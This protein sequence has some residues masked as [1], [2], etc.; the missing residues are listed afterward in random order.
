MLHDT[1][2]AGIGSPHGADR[3][4]WAVIDAL[5]AQALPPSVKL[6]A[7]S[8]PTEL[9]PL[10][11]SSARVIVVDA[12]LGAGPAGA[13]HRLRAAELPGTALRLSS[14]GVGL[15]DA[16]LLASALGMPEDRLWVL[17]LDVLD[18]EAEIEA[19]WIR[20]LVAQVT[21]LLETD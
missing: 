7:C 13:I 1:L 20:A 19:G 21:S 3:L 16:V 15:A 6:L 17:A 2:I 4:G 18:P 9:T 11:L 12:L 5:R 10:L 8:L 14:H